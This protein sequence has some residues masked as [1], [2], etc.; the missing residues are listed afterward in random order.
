MTPT[1]PNP[2]PHPTDNTEHPVAPAIDGR[3]VDDDG[4]IDSVVE[5]SEDSFP[6]SDPP[7]W[8]RRPKPVEAETT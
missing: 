2:R 6:A 3:A 7:S 1:D 8:T 5:A 4:E